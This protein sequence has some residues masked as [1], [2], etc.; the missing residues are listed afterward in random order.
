MPIYYVSKAL[1]EA[2]LRYPMVE[3]LALALVTTG[4]RLKYYFQS[5][6]VV[7]R[8]DLPLKKA[9]QR[10]ELSGRLVRWA[11]QLGDYGIKYEARKASKAQALADFIVESSG[12]S[13]PVPY[14]AQTWKLF[15]DGAK[16]EHGAGARIILRGPDRI[17]MKY[18]VKICFEIINN[19][20]EYEALIAGLALAVE[21]KAE[22][23]KIFSDSQLVVDNVIGGFQVKDELLI[24]YLARVRELL[25]AIEREGVQ[26]TIQQIDRTENEEANLVAKSA[27]TGGTLYR[28]LEM[29]EEQ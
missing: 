15:V 28:S 9:M 26:W 11:M 29:R 18:G 14:K 17:T 5:Y 4:E 20:A 22:D 12:G 3:K 19:A 27:S 6:P 13:E 24:K 10:P 8:T 25:M 21:V 23:L 2:E 1:R 16:N 7:V